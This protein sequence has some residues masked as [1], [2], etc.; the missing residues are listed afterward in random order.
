MTLLWLLLRLQRAI[1]YLPL[2]HGVTMGYIPFG[3]SPRLCSKPFTCVQCLGVLSCGLRSV[4][5]RNRLLVHNFLECHLIKL[6]SSIARNRLLVYN[7]LECHLI[8]LLTSIARN[9]SC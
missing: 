2:T 9:V 5:A 3:A 4:I 6:L 8:K 1:S 7:V